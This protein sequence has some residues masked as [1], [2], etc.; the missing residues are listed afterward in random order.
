MTHKERQQ[1][2]LQWKMDP[3][4]FEKRAHEAMSKLLELVTN[5]PELDERTREERE[6]I[7]KENWQFLAQVL[8]TLKSKEFIP[9]HEKVGAAFT[10]LFSAHVGRDW[11]NAKRDRTEAKRNLGDLIPAAMIKEKVV[12]MFPEAA[13]ATPQQYSKAFRKIGLPPFKKKPR[14]K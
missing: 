12:A 10:Q 14:S 3:Q 7:F 2:R 8:E 4:G 13:N 11:L 9:F 1:L 5:L 6:A